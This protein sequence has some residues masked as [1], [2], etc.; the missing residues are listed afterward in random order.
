MLRAARSANARATMR[1]ASATGAAVALSRFMAP[2]VVS[3]SR[4]GSADADR[5]PAM[6]AAAQN[7]GQRGGPTSRFSGPTRSPVRKASR[8]GPSWACSSNS[9][10]RRIASLEEAT[11][12]SLPAGEA[13]ITPAAETPSRLT[14]RSASPVSKSTTSKSST[15]RAG[16]LHQGPHHVGF[17]GHLRS[18][19]GHLARCRIQAQDTHIHRNSGPPDPAGS[20]GAYRY[21]ILRLLDRGGRVR[22]SVRARQPA[23]IPRAYGRSPGRGCARCCAIRTA[24]GRS[25]A[26]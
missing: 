21:V 2:R 14:H 7:N 13:S 9:S 23:W 8:H 22:G 12:P 25:R 16:H 15:K 3:R 18:P 4:S 26:R 20:T 6:T 24:R 11:S 5:N 19:P 1:S 17:S 10:S